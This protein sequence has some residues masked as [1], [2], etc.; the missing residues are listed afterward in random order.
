MVTLFILI[1]SAQ[2]SS[3]QRLAGSYRFLINVLTDFP[4]LGAVGDPGWGGGGGPRGEGC[5]RAGRR[6]N[7]GRDYIWA[8]KYSSH[9]CKSRVARASPGTA[10]LPRRCF[11]MHQLR[12]A[13]STPPPALARPPSAP[14]AS[15]RRRQRKLKVRRT[16]RLT[17]ALLSS[18]ASPFSPALQEQL[19]M[20]GYGCSR[21]TYWV[22]LVA[23]P[24]SV[25]ENRSPPF[26]SVLEAP[27][28]PLFGRISDKGW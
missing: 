13:A 11:E 28:A 22:P 17:R 5:W 14:A 1:S 2:I 27:P 23:P 6:E 25:P 7:C 19:L 24:G 4:D 26:L 10:S 9:A 12:W 16:N 8:M 18:S 21:W 15:E 20:P 3:S